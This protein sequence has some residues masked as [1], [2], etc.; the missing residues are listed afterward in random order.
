MGAL[1]TCAGA[2]LQ[3][4]AVYLP[5]RGA[6]LARLV[7]DTPKKPT[8]QVTIAA[9]KGFT[10]KGTVIDPGGVFFHSAHVLVVGGAGGLKKLCTPAAY[11]GASLSDPLNA[12][13]ATGGETL[14]S[15]VSASVTGLI[16]QQ[17]TV[18]SVPVSAALDDLCGAASEALGKVI[19]WRVLDDGTVWLGEETWPAA[20]MPA[21]SDLLEVFPAEGRYVI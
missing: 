2:D 16:L 17:W 3:E 4:G 13:L 15:T 14:S 5:A 19:T 8:G 21:G 7:L 20:K 11:H 10:L 1:V 18:V 6:W 9:E 12:V